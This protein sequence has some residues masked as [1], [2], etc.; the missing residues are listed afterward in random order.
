MVSSTAAERFFAAPVLAGLDSASRL[1]LLKVLEEQRA[2]SGAILLQQGEPNDHIAFL[3]E[4]TATVF[5]PDARGHRETL[6][7]LTAPTM[8]GLSS[9]FRPF[10]PDFSVRATADVWLLNLDH[11]AHERLRR[12]DLRAAEQLAVAAVRVLADHFDLFDH[13]I[14]A[15]L[16]EPPDDH[17]KGTEWAD[18]RA[19]LFEESSS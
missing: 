4:G 9:F 7:N 5:R 14:S 16:A 10:P 19:R 6:A 13:R 18:F 1:A 15:Y 12:I 11:T 3:I 17:P 8:F 2:P